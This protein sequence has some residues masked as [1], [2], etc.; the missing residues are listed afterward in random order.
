MIQKIV[1]TYLFK[2]ITLF[3]RISYFFY[4]LLQLTPTGISCLK[5]L[6][7]C[8]TIISLFGYILHLFAFHILCHRLPS[9]FHSGRRKAN[10]HRTLCALDSLYISAAFFLKHFLHYRQNIHLRYVFCKYPKGMICLFF[11]LHVPMTQV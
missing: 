2:S 11:D 5:D 7:H 4:F 3:S 1:V 10:I 9:T 6:F 8:H